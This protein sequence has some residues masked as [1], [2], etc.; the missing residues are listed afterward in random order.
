MTE[1]LQIIYRKLDY[2]ARMKSDVE[3]SVEKMAGPL[4]KIRQ[5]DVVGLTLDERETISAFTTR[6]ATYQEQIG[7]MMRSIA[8]EEES[9]ITP[10]GAI[11]ALMEKLGILD[12]TEKWKVIRELRNQVNHEYASDPGELSDV[13]GR[14]VEN[15]PYLV[16]LHVKLQSF[17]AR[18]YRS[19]PPGG[20]AR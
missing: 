20:S 2:L 8:I 17:V 4:Q 1:N 18:S 11:L 9:A 3:H 13:L 15:V 10:F 16:D 19:P 7:R 12:D 6:F 14:M 5:G